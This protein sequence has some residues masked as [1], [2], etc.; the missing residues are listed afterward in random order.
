MHC[1]FL[2]NFHRI[3]IYSIELKFHLILFIYFFYFII[4]SIG[5]E[6]IQSFFYMNLPSGFTRDY[7]KTK[8]KK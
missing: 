4:F 7:N 1:D 3:Y 6:V 8:I 2:V 5:M